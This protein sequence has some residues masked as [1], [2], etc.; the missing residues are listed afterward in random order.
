M[1][2][3]QKNDDST[4]LN[5]VVNAVSPAS[6]QTIV[7]TDGLTEDIGN[8]LQAKI[9]S[10]EPA[11]KEHPA[12]PSDA[13]KAGKQPSGGDKKLESGMDKASVGV[14]AVSLGVGAANIYKEY[15]SSSKE[16]TAG[17]DN[18]KGPNSSANSSDTKN[19]SQDKQSLGEDTA[20]KTS[21][22]TPS[23]TPN[24]T[25]S[26]VGSS[27][28]GVEDK[29]S[30]PVADNNA[31]PSNLPDEGSVGTNAD[32]YSVVVYDDNGDGIMDRGEAVIVSADQA[33]EYH[34][35]GFN[36]GSQPLSGAPVSGQPEDG[37]ANIADYQEIEIYVDGGMDISWDGLNE[38]IAQDEPVLDAVVEGG[39]EDLPTGFFETI[40]WDEL[41]DAEIGTIPEYIDNLKQ[42]GEQYG[43]LDL[44]SEVP[45]QT[46]E[47][48]AAHPS[49][50]QA[51]GGGDE[52]SYSDEVSEYDIPGD[53]DFDEDQDFTMGDDSVA[54]ID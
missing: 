46:I 42:E 28:I 14:G 22:E 8:I 38:I 32:F 6:D 4:V 45:I 49:E 48:G 51:V 33:I 27:N 1:S 29:P 19:S 30:A 41:G 34:A 15:S 16:D 10:A 13:G 40:D 52:I 43:T 12:K 31:Q 35:W 54:T 7:D 50:P 18:A 21:E 24:N 20:A 53:M 36:D 37:I 17:P 2:Q 25:P 3:H 39:I 47:D 26:A 11:S 9:E 44:A 23:L 5:T